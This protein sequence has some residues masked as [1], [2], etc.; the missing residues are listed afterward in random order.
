[1]MMVP[2]YPPYNYMM[3]PSAPYTASMTPMPRSLSP[4]S[5]PHV[6]L[7]LGHVRFGAGMTHVSEPLIGQS[8]GGHMFGGGGSG[9]MGSRQ[10]GL[11]SHLHSQGGAAAAAAGAGAYFS[12]RGVHMNL[13]GRRE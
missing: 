6:P 13:N 4:G 9:S 11:V 8:P 5:L 7:P 10:N 3:Q 12:G 2:M 1:M